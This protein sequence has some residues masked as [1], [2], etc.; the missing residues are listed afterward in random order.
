MPKKPKRRTIASYRAASLKAARTRRQMKL[1]REQHDTEMGINF[2]RNM[3]A[4]LHRQTTLED[5]LP[6]ERT[7]NRVPKVEWGND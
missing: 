3:Y 2:V 1:A 6:P 4:A 7:I 5:M